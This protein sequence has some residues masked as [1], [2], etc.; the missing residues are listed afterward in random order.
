MDL[1]NLSVMNMLQNKMQYNTARQNVISQNIA[2]VDTPEYRR[3][4]IAK[5]SFKGMVKN[6]MLSLETTNGMH[7]SGINSAS[8]LVPYATEDK[9]EL[10]MEAFE[11]MKNNSEFAQA[12]ATYKKMIGLLKE[13]VG[14]SSSR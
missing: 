13:A 12:S 4:D 6:S 7:I 9:V 8:N 11:M 3:R 14:G 5:P 10:D 2:N 1:N